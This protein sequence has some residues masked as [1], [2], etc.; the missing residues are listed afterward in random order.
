[1]GSKG[2]FCCFF[3]P[4][5]D[6]DEK[7]LDDKCPSCGR[8]YCFPLLVPP[9]KIVDYEVEK[10]LGRGF[11]GATYIVKS[12]GFI[13]RPYVVKITPT[14][15]ESFF[16]KAP[17]LDEVRLHAELAKN[18]A[19]VAGIE[20]AHP[21]QIIK[22]PD[23][24]EL[25]CDVTVLEYIDG[26]LLQ[27]YLTGDVEPT[28]QEVCQ[29][30]VDLLSIRAEFEEKQLNHN[31]LHAENLIVEKLRPEGRRRDAICD[32]I[33]V[34]AIDLGSIS[35][36]SKSTDKRYGDVAFIATH[37]ESLLA[38]L[39]FSSNRLDDRDFR[40]ALALQGVVQGLLTAGQNA[41]L[42]KYDDL[43]HQI[44]DTYNRASHPWRPWRTPL[45]LRGFGDHYNAQTLESWDVPRLR[46]DPNDRW[47]AAIT[48]P[49]PQIITGMRGCGK[50]MLLR[51]LDLHAR[52]SAR[53]PEEPTPKIL[54]RIR[55]DKFVGLF[56]SAQRLLDLRH[57]SLSKLEFRL[58]RLFVNYGLQAARALLHIKDIAPDTLV[59]GAH[60]VL[61]AAISSFLEGGES[62]GAATS[63]EDLERRLT[64]LLVLTTQQTTPISIKA[65]P[66]SMFTH[67]AEQLRGCAEVFSS[68]TVFFLLDDVSTRYLEIDRIDELLSALLFQSPVCAF[69]FTSEWQTIELGLKSPGREHPV[70][71]GR[72]LTV[73]DLG[74]DV[75]EAVNAQ[76][77]KGKNFVS[78]ILE[79]RAALHI[80]HP[81]IKPKD[82]LG[83]VALEQVAREIAASNETSA[84]KKNAYRGLSCLA[85]VCVGDL[86]DVIKLYE[87]MI[88][89]NPKGNPGQIPDSVQSECFRELSSRRLYDLNRRRGYFKDHALAFAGASNELLVRSYR[90]SNKAS[91]A[92]PRL[93]QYS[94]IYVRVTTDDINSR[95]QQIDRLREL[96]DASV[97]VFSGASP[98]KKTKDSNPTQQFILSYRKIYGISSFI[99]LGD[100][101]RFELSGKD[102][103][104]WLENPSKAKEILLR[105]QIEEEFEALGGDGGG[106]PPPENIEPT[107]DVEGT[108]TPQPIPT[109]PDLFSVAAAPSVSQFVA[110]PQ[111]LAVS[112]VE[113][114]LEQLAQRPISTILTS[115]GFEDRTLASNQMLAE[116]TRP[117][118]VLAVSYAA[119]GYAA[120]ILTAWQKSGREAEQFSYHASSGMPDLG[121][122]V[123]LIDISGLTKPL[124]F[125]SIR[126]QLIQ[127]QKA[128]VCYAAAQQYY[129][130]QSDLEALFAAEGASDQT[131]F[132]DRLAAVLTGEV[133]P[134]ETVR[135]MTEDSD[136]SRSRALMA[137]SSPKHE[138]LLTL[139]DKREFDYIEVF[140][141]E[142]ETPRAKVS[143]L[144]ADFVKKNYPNA[145][146][147][148]ID[149]ENIAEMLRRIDQR[150]LETYLA[151][152]ANVE[153]GLTGSKL[154]AVVAAVLA[155]KR[156]IAQAWYVSP[157]GFDENRFSKG[158]GEIKVFE[159][160]T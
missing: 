140:A 4:A 28:V 11:Y 105:N 25:E 75:L 104:E 9:V 129:P 119:P 63:L 138:R 131:M 14:S 99:G 56:V 57:Q 74:A 39:L 89:R 50:T 116:H 47:F 42:P 49:G 76:G 22:F 21:Q 13:P 103:E 136:P 85:N 36:Q 98:R 114:P 128:Y 113:V 110:E 20:N 65:D 73:F 10:S 151:A 43:I 92:R 60:R 93:R 7:S 31:D 68:S 32:Y 23:G 141:P 18:A 154:Q 6:Y 62:L 3:C 81:R 102:L 38:R 82:L 132:L 5:K 46:V 115:L 106:L 8:Q 67:L 33:R 109:Q 88:R 157:K 143:A 145:D 120:E 125:E 40:I 148:G 156:K 117:D 144:A 80:P 146:V 26:D 147:I 152:G 66:A 97:F 83:D 86:G 59:I 91:G 51:A 78:Q 16:S 54:E 2:K 139:L 19:H 160:S 64:N 90:L 127:N 121:E 48:K 100:R 134:Y 124:I 142:K 58:T 107:H 55:S 29:I 158:I 77:N 108:Q 111:P 72:D 17:F 44:H 15:F 1:M 53:D 12:S 95:K 101:D 84:A 70:R 71:E 61:A 112:V 130:L 79:Q 153:L 35:D 96:I 123:S 133:G 150:Y 24:S 52:A 122:G 94:T 27:S 37:V 137:F 69:K 87:E 126:R 135:L 45:N 41:R 159:I 118:R 30:A 34:K 149:A 155:S